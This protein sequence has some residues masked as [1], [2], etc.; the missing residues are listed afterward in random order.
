MQ[1]LL[2]LLCPFVAQPLQTRGLPLLCSSVAQL[3][4]ARRLALPWPAC[5]LL[6]CCG[7]PAA[8]AIRLRLVGVLCRELTALKEAYNIAFC[9]VACLSSMS[10]SCSLAAGHTLT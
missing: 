9:A 5:P 10:H 2:L 7:G 1:R 4:P 6:A 8:D 3:L